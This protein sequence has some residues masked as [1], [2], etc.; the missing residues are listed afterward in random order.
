[1]SSADPPSFWPG[2]FKMLATQLTQNTTPYRNVA[3]WSTFDGVNL[4]I[5]PSAGTI[6]H[7]L[8]V[9]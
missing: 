4:S 8:F 3:G 5:S 7:G 1:M 9:G 6:N 2:E